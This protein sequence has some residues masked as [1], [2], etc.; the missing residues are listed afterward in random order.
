MAA[1][2]AATSRAAWR[3]DEF[4]SNASAASR[5]ALS[6]SSSSMTTEALERNHRAGEPVAG[7]LGAVALRVPAG[8]GDDPL[9]P[10][11]PL[12]LVAAGGLGE[13]AERRDQAR[14]RDEPLV[15]DPRRKR[16]RSPGDLAAT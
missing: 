9:L 3:Y 7:D 8:R 6:D 2:S 14:A 11:G 12:V 1:I 10:V 16:S 5:T 4:S 15:E 13:L